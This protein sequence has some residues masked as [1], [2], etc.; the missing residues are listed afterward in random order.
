MSELSYHC[1]CEFVL[2]T[3]E[4]PVG[5]SCDNIETGGQTY[6][7]SH[8]WQLF[9]WLLTSDSEAVIELGGPVGADL[10]SVHSTVPGA[11]L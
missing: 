1:G 11:R 9:S 8:T 3:P 5:S 10:T 7:H 2:Q 6:L 4:F